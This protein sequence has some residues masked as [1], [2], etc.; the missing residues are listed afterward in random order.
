MLEVDVGSRSVAEEL[1][2]AEEGDALNEDK[3]NAEY[4]KNADDDKKAREEKEATYDNKAE[5]ENGGGG[6]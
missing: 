1:E 6:E 4:L 3:T 2:K 5:E